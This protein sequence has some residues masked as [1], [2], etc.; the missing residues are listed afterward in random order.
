MLN[1]RGMKNQPAGV[2]MFRAL[3][4]RDEAADYAKLVSSRINTHSDATIARSLSE[5]LKLL[6]K[7]ER[8]TQTAVASGDWI[9]QAIS[10]EHLATQNNRTY[11]DIMSLPTPRKLKPA[12]QAQ[13]RALVAQKAQGLSP[14][15]RRRFK[16]RST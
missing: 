11:Q 14:E 10:L 3:Y 5:R 6:N 2:A 8:E 12:Q 7:Q 13:Y 15:K 4:L 1:V 9:S 16:P